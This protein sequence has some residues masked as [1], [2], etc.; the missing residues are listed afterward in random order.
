MLD[1]TKLIIVDDFE[2][3]I[4]EMKDC[5]KQ[6]GINDVF[7]CNNVSDLSNEI[8]RTPLN[9]LI[10]VSVSDDLQDFDKIVYCLERENVLSCTIFLMNMQDKTGLQ[11]VDNHN[12]Q[13]LDASKTFGQ[14]TMEALLTIRDEIIAQEQ[15]DMSQQNYSTAPQGSQTNSSKNPTN[16]QP[17]QQQ[18]DYHDSTKDAFTL[19]LASPKGGTGKS[20]LAM[21]ISY[22]LAQ[23]HNKKICLVDLNPSFDTLSATIGCVRRTENYKTLYNWINMLQDRCYNLMSDEE[24]HQMKTE[25]D[26]DFLPYLEKYDVHLTKEDIQQLLIK[27]PKTGAKNKRNGGLWILPAIALPY[28]VEYVPREYVRQIL[29]TLKSYFDYII[30]DTADN[31]S[32]ITIEGYQESDRIFLVSNHTA[33]SAAVIAKLLNNLENIGLTLDDFDLIINSP[34]GNYFETDPENISNTLNIPLLGILP[35]EEKMQKAHAKGRPYNPFNPKS[36]FSK[37]L[38]PI[39]NQIKE[40]AYNKKKG[41]F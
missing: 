28:D 29:R 9:I 6:T 17:Y 4:N 7:V 37:A 27:D 11:L 21:E 25:Q 5:A 32:Y 13:W 26:N 33:A 12:G 40:D 8:S 35:F 10:L 18:Y 31:L 15:E 38:I 22:G 34:N 36:R 2:D 24:R 39:L 23:D 14:D 3:Y 1:D 16:S 41:R 30:V 20:S 19:V